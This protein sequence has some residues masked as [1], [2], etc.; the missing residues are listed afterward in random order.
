MTC[1][2]S[3]QWFCNDRS[4]CR[5]ARDVQAIARF[6]DQQ[7]VTARS[8]GRLKKSVGLVVNSLAA[9]VNADE[10]I[11]PIVVGRDVIVCDRPVVAHS[12]E[13]LP[14]EIVRPESERDAAPV[15]GAPTKHSRPPP[16]EV[17]PG[18]FRIWLAIDFPSAFAAVEFTE[19]LEPCRSASTRRCVIGKHHLRILRCVPRIAR[20]HENYVGACLGEHVCGHSAAGTRA[21]DAD[22]ECLA[23]WFH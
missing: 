5:Y 23:R 11:D 9:P 12:I 4:P 1:G 2:A 18:R 20:F 16:E 17:C 7:L 8:R 6:L 21:Y 13:A 10:L 14:A 3:V 15:I 19:R 22:V